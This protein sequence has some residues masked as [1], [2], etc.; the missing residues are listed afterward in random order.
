LIEVEPWS[1]NS[2][3]K[4]VICRA[5]VLEKLLAVGHIGREAG[6]AIVAGY[7]VPTKPVWITEKKSGEKPYQEMQMK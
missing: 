2:D 7:G 5:V 1:I 3:G 4:V 6:R